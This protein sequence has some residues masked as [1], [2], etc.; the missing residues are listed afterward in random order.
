MFG[1]I[2]TPSSA[3]TEIVVTFGEDQGRVPLTATIGTFAGEVAIKLEAGEAIEG[4]GA[5]AS[6]LRF[7]ADLAD[8]VRKV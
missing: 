2:T 4:V 8:Y 1:R 3:P 5:R 7:L 6:T